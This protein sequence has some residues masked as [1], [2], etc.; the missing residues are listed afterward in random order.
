LYYYGVWME[1]TAEDVLLG[2][3]TKAVVAVTFL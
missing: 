2:K 3:L 1:Y